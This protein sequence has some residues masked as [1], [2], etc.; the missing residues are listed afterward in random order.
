MRK[1]FDFNSIIKKIN[2]LNDI[3]RNRLFHYLKIKYPED[4]VL[5][6]AFIV[7][8]N[9]NFWNNEEDDVYNNF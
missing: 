1:D 4:I 9:Y 3:D 6:N 5:K 7:G 8:E 2:S